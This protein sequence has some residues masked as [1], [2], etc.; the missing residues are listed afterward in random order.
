MHIYMHEHYSNTFKL[1][2]IAVEG[3]TSTTVYKLVPSLYR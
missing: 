1:H 2:G 3:S